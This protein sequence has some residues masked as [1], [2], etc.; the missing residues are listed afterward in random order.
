MIGS[1][2]PGFI[3]VCQS[4]VFSDCLLVSGVIGF[5]ALAAFRMV[6]SDCLLPAIGLFSAANLQAGF[7]SSSGR[8]LV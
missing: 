7:L 4:L 6:F 5:R 3:N 2:N 8:F 1:A